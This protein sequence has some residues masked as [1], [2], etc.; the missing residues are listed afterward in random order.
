MLA[1][2]CLSHCGYLTISVMVV[3]SMCAFCLHLPCVSSSLWLYL[4]SS[5]VLSLSFRICPCACVSVRCVGSHVVDLGLKLWVITPIMNHHALFRLSSPVGIDCI[6]KLSFSL[7]NTLCPHITLL[8]NMALNMESDMSRFILHE[9]KPDHL[10]GDVVLESFGNLLSFVC[11]VRQHDHLE[12]LV[13]AY[14]F[15]CGRLSLTPYEP[16]VRPQLVFNLTE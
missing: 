3:P 10:G 13:H 14:G 7:S 12:C 15:K 8:T 6:M 16:A 4:S 2:L 11:G 5:V 1:S 9:I